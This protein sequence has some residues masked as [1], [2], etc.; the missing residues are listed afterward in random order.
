MVIC[1][2]M[3]SN[4]VLKAQVAFI[5]PISGRNLDQ[6]RKDIK[7][8]FPEITDDCIKSMNNETRDIIVNVVNMAMDDCQKNERLKELESKIVDNCNR[9]QLA[10]E[11]AS[12]DP[13]GFEQALNS[14]NIEQEMTN[15]LESFL[16]ISNTIDQS[17]TPFS[18][19]QKMCNKILDVVPSVNNPNRDLA[20]GFHKLSISL[21]NNISFSYDYLTY[22]I[23]KPTNC[24]P[25]TVEDIFT[26][27]FN[28]A[29]LKANENIDKNEP[30]F[31]G[32]F[33]SEKTA[34]MALLRKEIENIGIEKQ[35]TE[36]AADFTVN[37][38]ATNS[39]DAAYDCAT[40]FVDLRGLKIREL[41]P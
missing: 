17:V 4:G 31:P 30:I 37:P 2:L 28:S 22:N 24:A 39:P 36:R 41:C 21:N 6:Q 1:L 34:F 8:I 19:N 25:L 13:F 40:K 29:I 7:T 27:A 16:G 3:N 23:T 32:S 20:V 18:A 33:T 14:W 5:C 38:I 35:C 9:N 12:N 10:S 15:S 11:T 26:Q